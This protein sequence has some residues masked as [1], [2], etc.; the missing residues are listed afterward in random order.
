V[1]I[2]AENSWPE[3]LEF[4]L[5]LVCD[6]VAEGDENTKLWGLRVMALVVWQCPVGAIQDA[7]EDILSSFI[8]EAG[9]NGSAI[10]SIRRVRITGDLC[11]A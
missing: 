11:S 10:A 6:V 3:K 4:A 7:A 2:S 5:E 9:L 8:A 1:S